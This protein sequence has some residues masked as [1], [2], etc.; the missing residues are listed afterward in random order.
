MMTDLQEGLNLRISPYGLFVVR[1]NKDQLRR[2]FLFVKSR[3]K[4]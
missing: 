3:N 1:E 4:A 2:V